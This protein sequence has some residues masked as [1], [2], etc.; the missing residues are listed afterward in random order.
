MPRRT[1]LPKS[2][3]PLA[4]RNGIEVGYDP[5]F[6][7]DM[8]RLVKGLKGMLGQ[9]VAA[10][11]EAKKGNE[12]VV[13]VQQ[14]PKYDLRGA[15]FAGGFAETVAGDQ[16]GGTL[17]KPGGSKA[18]P[19]KPQPA[20]AK[21]QTPGPFTEDLGNGAMLDMVH[22]PARD[23][24][25]GSPENEAEREDSEGPRHRVQVPAFYM[26]KYP[27]TQAQW[28]AVAK[29]QQVKVELKLAP[30]RFKGN[31]LPV[32]RVSWFEAVEFC[33][34]L[35]RHTGNQYH[36][37]SEAEWEYACRAR[38]TTPFYFGETISTDQANYDGR[39]TYGNGKK[40]QFRKKTT[41]VGSFPA[42]NFG[43]YDM[44]GNV[45]EWCQD[46]WHEDYDGAPQDGS[47]WIQGGDSDSRV[48]RGG[49]WFSYPRLCRSAYRNFL[50]P[51]FRNGSSGFRVVC[52]APRI[53]P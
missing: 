12:K 46:H 9:D 48:V 11:P 33:Q 51:V 45:W 24:L 29:L 35:S 41:P 23:F 16:V 3:Q 37:P 39:Y 38:T 26:G 6:R 43:L 27:V 21:P 49:S 34:R 19:P 8:N 22:I 1:Q 14:G 47:P 20:V 50:T 7:A 52:S 4:R 13:V 32:E 53:L 40:G 18:E 36:L 17:N 30:S 25:M 44:H 42:N 2:L 10:A 5:R 31:D 15:Q 28:Q